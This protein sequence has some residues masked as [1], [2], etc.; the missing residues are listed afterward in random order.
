MVRRLSESR[1]R[2]HVKENNEVRW[3]EREGKQ[4]SRREKIRKTTGKKQKKNK[5]NLCTSDQNF[6]AFV[7]SSVRAS[8]SPH[9]I[10][11]DLII[12]KKM[13]VF[14]YVAP[15]SL[16]EIDRRFTGACIIALIMEAVSTSET[17]VS[18]YEATRHRTRGDSDHTRRRENLKSH[19][20]TNIL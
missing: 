20:I 12:N 5:I 16:V 7:V 15:R 9:L 10:L 4:E 18:L 1:S 2:I 19:L 11:V 8:S 3:K 14:W 13:S 17:S 6:F